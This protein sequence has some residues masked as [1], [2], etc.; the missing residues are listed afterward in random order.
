MRRCSFASLYLDDTFTIAASGVTDYGA[1][2]IDHVTEDS[3]GIEDS[4]V[5]YTDKELDEMAE[6]FARQWPLTCRD[7][8]GDEVELTREQAAAGYLKC[9]EYLRDKACDEQ[10]NA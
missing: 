5:N 4:L 1:V 10:V 9:L 3:F 8:Y 6:H 7:D 2:V